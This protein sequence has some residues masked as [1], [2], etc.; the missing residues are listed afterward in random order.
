MRDIWG[1]E[2]LPGDQ[3]G[4]L[5]IVSRIPGITYYRRTKGLIRG[6]SASGF[7][8]DILGPYVG[9]HTKPTDPDPNILIQIE[10]D[11]KDSREE[12]Q[13]VQIVPIVGHWPPPE[14]LA[15]DSERAAQGGR[16]VYGK[17][18]K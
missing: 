16:F 17:V 12:R 18:R 15:D 7:Q 3:L 14:F 6:T 2:L 13:N 8:E 11:Y 5:Y 1:I 4:F 10:P 9:K